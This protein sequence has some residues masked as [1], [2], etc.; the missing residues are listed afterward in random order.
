MVPKRN[1]G[2]GTASPRQIKRYAELLSHLDVTPAGELGSV[3]YIAPGQLNN[4]RI[5][6]S[7]IHDA[8]ESGARW[9]LDEVADGTIDYFPVRTDR[10][11]INDVG[12]LFTS[13]R[14]KSAGLRNRAKLAI[15][16]TTSD[17][18]RMAAEATLDLYMPLLY[19]KDAPVGMSIDEY[20]DNL[21]DYSRLQYARNGEIEGKQTHHILEIAGA[22]RYLQAFRNPEARLTAMTRLLDQGLVPADI[23]TNFSALYGNTAVGKGVVPVDTRPRGKQSDQH[24]GG[25]H[26]EILRLEQQVGL[27]NSRNTVDEKRVPVPREVKKKGQAAIDLHKA[28]VDYDDSRRTVEKYMGGL[29]DDQQQAAFELWGNVSNLANKQAHAGGTLQ[30]SDPQVREVLDRIGESRA[31]LDSPEVAKAKANARSWLGIDF[32]EELLDSYA[33]PPID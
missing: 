27:P 14:G 12:V 10:G 2:K 28:M 24:Q 29:T 3:P 4:K 20:R 18:R 16:D 7:N 32:E 22:N 6:K 31:V 30:G 13:G 21:L 9:A 17:T 1:R 33:G 8:A 15:D 5:L 26:P 19:K 11:D 25:V 23:A